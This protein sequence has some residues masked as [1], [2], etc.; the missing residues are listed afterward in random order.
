MCKLLF[1]LLIASNSKCMYLATI[2]NIGTTINM[3]VC[4]CVCVCVWAGI[5]QSV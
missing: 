4:V 2:P 1:L 3:Y 5:A